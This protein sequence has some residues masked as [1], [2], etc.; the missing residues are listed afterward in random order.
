[1]VKNSC[2]YLISKLNNCNY[3]NSCKY[4]ISKLNNCNYNVCVL[5]AL[6]KA[7]QAKAAA[8]ESSNDVKMALRD[9]NEILRQLGKHLVVSAL[10]L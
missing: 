5:Q 7:D 8:V 10:F 2:K 4:L 3:K 6:A 1:M 9:V